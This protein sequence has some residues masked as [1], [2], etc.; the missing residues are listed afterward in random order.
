MMNDVAV[1]P[2]LRIDAMRAMPAAAAVSATVPNA[3]TALV[4]GDA[5]APMCV[6]PV[7]LAVGSAL[8]LMYYPAMVIDMIWHVVIQCRGR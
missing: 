2:Q 4:L 5:L 3:M 1:T 7:A 6:L 8:V